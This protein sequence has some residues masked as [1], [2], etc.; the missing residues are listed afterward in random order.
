[1]MGSPMNIVLTGASSGIGAALTEALA[2]DG[3]RLFVCA[4]RGDRLRQVTQNGA[5][6]TPFVCDVGDPNQ[7]EAFATKVRTEVSHVDALINCAGAYGAIGEVMDVDSEAWFATLRTNILGTM[8]A[9]QQF[10]PAMRKAERPV[11]IN[12]AGGGAF[13]PLPN[14]SAYAVSK[15]GVVRLTETLAVE[16]SSRNVCVNAVAPGFVTTEIHEAT[17]AAGPD[18]AGQALYDMTRE[19]LQQGAVPIETPI[20]CVRFLLSDQAAGLTGK[21]LS[22]SFD[23]WNTD[24]FQNNIDKINASELYS[25]KRINLVHLQDD[26]MDDGG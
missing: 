18:R 12:F 20:N 9:V 2:A 8:M 11:V 23:P 1:M 22:A 24:G 15:A 7:L 10:V 21:T 25:M 14:Y 6:A 4:R 26:P 3:H 16:L 17:L 5:I 19:K 13:D